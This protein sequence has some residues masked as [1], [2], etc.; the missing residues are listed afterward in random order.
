MNRVKSY[1]KMVKDK[2]MTPVLGMQRRNEGRALSS[3]FIK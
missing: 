1:G 3:S 2:Y